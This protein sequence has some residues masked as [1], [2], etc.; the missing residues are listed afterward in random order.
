MCLSAGESLLSAGSTVQK[1]RDTDERDVASGRLGRSSRD[2]VIS[3]F[4]P[5]RSLVIK[6]CCTYLEY[7][8]VADG[9]GGRG[10][11]EPRTFEN[12]GGRP[13]QK[14]GYFSIFFL[15]T[16]IFAFS[17]LFKINSPKSEEK[18]NFG[19]RWVWVPMNP[20]P[21]GVATTFCLGGRIHGRGP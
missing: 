16:F 19:G 7:R 8:G 17:N 2:N 4:C 10:S 13:P 18:L 3:C 20:T 15:E 14:F 9:G 5:S 1:S 11:Q 21:R 12:C 6:L